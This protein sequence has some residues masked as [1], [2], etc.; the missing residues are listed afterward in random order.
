METLTSKGVTWH[1]SIKVNKGDLA[2]LQRKYDFHELD[3]EDCLSEHERP[4]VEEYETY[5]FLVFHIPYLHRPTGRILKEAPHKLCKKI[6]NFI[7]FSELKKLF[8]IGTF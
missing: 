4:K 2:K 5:L 6:Q 3:I 1:N 7:K 8:D